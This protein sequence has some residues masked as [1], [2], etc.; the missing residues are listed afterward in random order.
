ML[1]SARTARHPHGLPLRQRQAGTPGRAGAGWRP[2]RQF[3]PPLYAT[4]L[5]LADPCHDP[6]PP[7]TLSRAI[8][9]WPSLDRVLGP[10][11]PPP[12]ARTTLRL[13]AGPL[14]APLD[15][16]PNACQCPSLNWSLAGGH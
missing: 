4:S 15:P 8:H 12:Y 10:C 14:A 3:L 2:A 6:P 16:T 1:S 7:P 11:L 9:T 13:F 5:V